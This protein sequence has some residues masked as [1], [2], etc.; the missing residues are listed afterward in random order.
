MGRTKLINITNNRVRCLFYAIITFSLILLV[1]S[2]RSLQSTTK[3]TGA[4]PISV[5]H[6]SKGRLRKANYSRSIGFINAEKQ[7]RLQKLLS[8]QKNKIVDNPT[9]KNKSSDLYSEVTNKTFIPNKLSKF[10][11][12]RQETKAINPVKIKTN[13]ENKVIFKEAFNSTNDQVCK[14][15][16]LEPFD[17]E[18]SHLFYEP[19]PLECK[20]HLNSY[21][22][23]NS[24]FVR[25][26]ALVKEKYEVCQ[27]STIER[28]SDILSFITDP[29]IVPVGR[30]QD[31]KDL[32]LAYKVD[33]DFI[34][35][36]CDNP[37]ISANENDDQSLMEYEMD[38][39]RTHVDIHAHINPIDKVMKHA[40]SK[41]VSETSLGLNVIMFGVDSTSRLNFIRK[42]PNTY[43][44]LT[45]KIGSVVLKGYNIV[46]DAT[47]GAVTPMLTGKHEKEL[48]ETRRSF[49]NST[50]VDVYPFVWKDFKK[51]GYAT[52]FAE[53]TPEISTYNWRLKG[54]DHR[55]TD[56][57]MRTFWQ[58]VN[59]EGQ[60]LGP[61]PVHKVLLDYLQDFM[62]DYRKV[63]HFGFML[64]TGLTHADINKLSLMDD[65]L[66]TF[67]KKVH[68]DGL[69]NNTL[70]AIFSDHGARYTKI[71]ATLQ[72]KLEERLP[73]MSIYIPEWIRKK[74]PSIYK[75]IRL[76]SDRLTTPFDIHE[77]LKSV[78]NYNSVGNK[79]QRGLNLFNEIPLTRSCSG[80]GVAPHWCACLKWEMVPDGNQLEI[81]TI[82]EVV[83]E[84]LNRLVVP[85]IEHCAHIVLKSV[86]FAQRMIPNSEIL[87]F[88]K[89]VDFDQREP[90]F[91][92]EANVDVHEM[93]LLY[94]VTV[95]TAPGPGLFEATIKMSHDE[96][97]ITRYEITEEISRINLYGDQPKCIVNK[98]PKV[99]KYCYCKNQLNSGR[100]Q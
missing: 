59:I 50:Y 44:Y 63:P 9:D 20:G 41:H 13:L 89:T 79:N 98:Y 67:L 72:G 19:S 94:Q 54:F 11:I 74:H 66:V 46:G 36:G 76:N 26:D 93:S 2:F 4:M 88:D 33:S 80:A 78:L 53:D 85:F 58:E 99:A 92:K 28:D 97:N 56:H 84:E 30:A 77:T 12:T 81:N 10:S 48:P 91:L 31:G 70:L 71:R 17:L 1:V 57:Y 16:D 100:D 83:I 51:A 35:V 24:I 52:L 73:F 32:K 61:K 55:P 75:N 22:K 69:L 95:E 68:S 29:V 6:I 3:T 86:K 90:G 14:M 34:I 60:C 65:A 39:Q 40:Q 18:I 64:Y 5:H 8:M 27:V 25:Y 37:D 96:K 7:R 38:I 21:I 62:F 23:D 43:R 82:A 15:P 87:K 47:N 42:M 45:E 49:A